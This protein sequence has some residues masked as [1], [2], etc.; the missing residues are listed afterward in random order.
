MLPALAQ[1]QGSDLHNHF[2]TQLPGIR[3]LAY[4]ATST[5]TYIGVVNIILRAWAT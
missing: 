3:H 1:N 4:F 5:Y 2:E